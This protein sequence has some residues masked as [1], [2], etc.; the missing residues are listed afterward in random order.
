MVICNAFPPDVAAVAVS[1]EKFLAHVATVPEDGRSRLCAYS[2]VHDAHLYSP[3]K[4]RR[5]EGAKVRRYEGTKAGHSRVTWHSTGA[6]RQPC[7]A[8]CRENDRR[9][10]RDC[11]GSFRTVPA[12]LDN[13]G[14]EPSPWASRRTP[15]GV[16]RGE[17]ATMTAWSLCAGRQRCAMSPWGDRLASW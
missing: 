1:V 14:G 16:R 3:T 17:V 2:T 12:S 9:R 15:L 13:P 8:P 5:C 4:V 7:S 6:R 10:P 11:V